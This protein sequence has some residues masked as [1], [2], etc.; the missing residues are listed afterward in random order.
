MSGILAKQC[1]VQ[2]KNCDAFL[3]QHTKYALQMG[4]QGKACAV[5]LECTNNY[6]F[7]INK[8]KNIPRGVARMQIISKK[9]VRRKNNLLS[10]GFSSIIFGIEALRVERPQS[11]SPGLAAVS[12]FVSST[13][14][15]I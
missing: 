5:T 1:P 8:L 6:I 14:V 3:L 13:I 10:G 12:A 7:K 11:K 9:L 4:F 15:W 2:A